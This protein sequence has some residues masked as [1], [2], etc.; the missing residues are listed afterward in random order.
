MGGRGAR[1]VVLLVILGLLG[2][3]SS[4][5][6]AQPV[7][8]QR[9]L[10]IAELFES[11]GELQL[12]SNMYREVLK[13]D[14]QQAE[15]TRRVAEIADALEQP[16]SPT[17]AT[18]PP[19]RELVELTSADD[20]IPH[21]ATQ[22]PEVP[23]PEVPAPEVPAPID[24]KSE[25]DKFIAETSGLTQRGQAGKTITGVRNTESD[26]ESL[27]AA[28]TDG[29]PAVPSAAVVADDPAVGNAAV[30]TNEPVAPVSRQTAA[31]LESARTPPPE[32]AERVEL[33]WNA[34]P[35]GSRSAELSDTRPATH[36]K[37]TSSEAK[38][39]SVAQQ[40]AGTVAR[41]RGQLVKFRLRTRLNYQGALPYR[42]HQLDVVDDLPGRV[43]IREEI[44]AATHD[45]VVAS[46]FDRPLPS[47]VM[48]DVEQTPMP[49]SDEAEWAVDSH[50]RVLVD[51]LSD[52]DA[53]IRVMAAFE[54][55]ERTLESQAV[56]PALLNAMT[57]E[58]NP[59]V[60]VLLAEA[61][62]KISP[63]DERALQVLSQ[64]LNQDDVCVRQLAVLAVSEVVA[65]IADAEGDGQRVDTGDVWDRFVRD[66]SSGIRNA[67]HQESKP[68]RDA[69]RQAGG[70]M[71]IQESTT[72]TP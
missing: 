5:Q 11:Q 38:Q 24:V 44:P 9:L 18:V 39:P 25:A 52:S 15:A 4:R 70:W 47:P 34:L 23:V 57:K 67:M 20:P 13:S 51:G 65:R 14:P 62:A 2:C 3:Q 53:S 27:P 61:L 35:D 12:A 68:I 41:R 19:E 59:M 63:E 48:P 16:D 46:P 71:G 17:M 42:E 6:V 37:P 31:S 54:L 21:F 36:A 22:A 58:Q 66:V 49:D 28:E 32:S 56:I 40:V 8:Q 30:V 10:H 72:F 55:G 7:D 1:P 60:R 43:V 33:E 45:S 69:A 29:S 64:A 50:L 26:A